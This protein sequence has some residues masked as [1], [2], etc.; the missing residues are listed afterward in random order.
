MP[1]RFIGKLNPPERKGRGRHFDQSVRGLASTINKLRSEGF[2]DIGQLADRLNQAGAAAPNGGPFTY[3][4][5]RR[6]LIRLCGLRLGLGPQSR[7]AA[8]TQREKA[9]LQNY[10]KLWGTSSRRD[11]R[12][13]DLEQAKLRSPEGTL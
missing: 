1:V 10:E 3:G 7:S 11:R 8:A 4:S 6:V 13:G 2:H 9:K 12:G 5:M